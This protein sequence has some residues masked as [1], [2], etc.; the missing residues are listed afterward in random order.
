MIATK[1]AGFQSYFSQIQTSFVLQLFAPEH[2][3]FNPILV[4]YK[5]C[6]VRS[7]ID[8]LYPFQSYFSQ[9][10]TREGRTN[11]TRTNNSFQSYFSQ[12]QTQCSETGSQNSY[13]VSIL[14]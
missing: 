4:R 11:I 3:S 14:F 1:T 10:Q 7:S 9:I 13:T 8:M 12:I 5:R 2:P 6:Q